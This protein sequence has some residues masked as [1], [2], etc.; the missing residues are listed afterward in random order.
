M[1]E[2]EQA[3][4]ERAVMLHRQGRPKEAE[5]LYRALV[6]CGVRH[7]GVLQRLSEICFRSGR[8]AE[9]AD[10]LR[11]TLCTGPDDS[12]TM[13]NLGFMLHQIGRNDE[14]L[15]YLERSIV[16]RPNAAFTLT[17]LGN[18][19]AA[20]GRT[21]EAL[22]A[23]SKALTLDSS[24]PEPHNNIGNVLMSLGHHNEAREAFERALA[25]RPAFAD[26]LS[27]LGNALFKLG[28][29]AEAIACFERAL[30]L[31]PD[32][33]SAHYNWGTVLGECG[34]HEDA[35]E[36]YHMALQLDPNHAAAS[37][38]LGRSL[39]ALGKPQEALAAFDRALVIDPGFA[40]AHA[41][42]GS[43]L[44]YLGRKDDART[45]CEKA[46]ALAPGLAAAHRALS[47]VKRY[48]KDDPG[49]AQLEKLAARETAMGDIERS[50]LHF[51]MGKAYADCEDY[52]R[53]FEHYLKGNA[54]KRRL[55]AYDEAAHC[56][57]MRT[58][59]QM[60]TP[61]LLGA[62]LGNGVSSEMP[63]FI[64]GMP[65]SGT[66]L[67]EQI[68]ASHP[69]VY[70]AGEQA[71]F[72]K[73]VAGGYQP[74]P[75][76]VSAVRA[77]ELSRM[78]EIYVSRMTSKIP[79]HA[80]RFTDKMPA[81]FRFL[82]LIHLTLPNARI[83]HVHRDP[84]DTCTSCFTKLF[85]GS[86]DYTYDLAELGRY[87]RAYEGLM[88]HWRA[89]LPESAMLDVRYEDLVEN[90]EAGAQRIVDHCGL[91]WDARCLE[92]HRTERPVITASTAQV[93]E[94]LFKTSIGRWRV[95]QPWLGPLL[96]G[97][98]TLRHE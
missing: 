55:V 91:D 70:G 85:T 29:Q 39:N 75:F 92:F 72:G 27:N 49:I 1:T 43:A 3:Q 84:L 4:Y 28:R 51:A 59:A 71:E 11:E 80:S 45:A 15:T 33:A 21:D 88:D 37:N 44:L 22:V 20:K 5:Q 30:A 58:A 35:V 16:I 10:L 40:I 41:G 82:G 53:A 54:A 31:K 26:A 98:G 64:V 8:V 52:T 97:L 14:A 36:H 57:E 90:F 18:V 74:A 7:P 65:R 67:V 61:E 81:N 86:L 66:T 77:E 83:I 73:A 78:G 48:T 95:Y 50:E 25:I 79:A 23:F 68:L 2:A 24:L 9:A 76:D 46:V 17:N 89:V 47:E 69:L 94:P 12:Q 93:R 32:F 38:N 42:I 60:F 56:A 13:S 6:A 19:L 63:I 96:D 87:Y 62:K 34:R